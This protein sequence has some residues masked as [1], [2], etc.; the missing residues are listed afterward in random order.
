MRVEL[1]CHPDTP[2]AAVAAI[3]AEVE[4]TWKYGIALTYRLRGDLGSIRFPATA[5]PKF[6]DGLWQTTC[7]E[8]FVRDVGRPGY[9]EFNFSPS[10]A[11]AIYHFDDYRGGVK[12]GYCTHSPIKTA[13]NGNRFEMKTGADLLRGSHKGEGALQVGLSAVI[14]ET[15]G[16]KSYWALAHPPGKPDFHH[17]DGFVLEL[18]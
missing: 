18:P 13:V 7:F 1:K 5:E 2:S 3:E 17:P 9:S 11:Y 4:R 14:E 16:V 6:T 12:S 10:S 15:N 8:A